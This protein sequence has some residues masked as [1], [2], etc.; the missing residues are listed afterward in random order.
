[1]NSSPTPKTYQ[2]TFYSQYN[3]TT[4]P[5]QTPLTEPFTEKDRNQTSGHFTTIYTNP[6]TSKS[7]NTPTKTYREP[8]FQQKPYVPLYSSYIDHKNSDSP[9]ITFP[10]IHQ[11]I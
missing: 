11:N 2:Y 3:T 7:Y 4:P 5:K 1:M 9:P 10:C 6:C 8:I